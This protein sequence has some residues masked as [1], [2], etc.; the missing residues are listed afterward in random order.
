MPV[1]SPKDIKRILPEKL[2]YTLCWQQADY[3]I[4]PSCSRETIIS[5]LIPT[6][7]PGYL[8]CW[9]HVGYDSP[10]GSIMPGISSFLKAGISPLLAAGWV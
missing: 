10:A 7:R 9:L 1:Y 6:W 3:V 5:L 4:L 2:Y 8:R